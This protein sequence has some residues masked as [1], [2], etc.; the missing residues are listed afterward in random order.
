MVYESNNYNSD[1]KDLA[2]DLRQIYAKLLGEHLID[3]SEARKANN[4]YGWY[5]SL[6]DIK[7]ISKHKWRDLEKTEKAYNI[8]VEAIKELANKYPNAWLGKQ[9][10]NNQ[11]E[12]IEN[13]LRDLEEFL[14]QQ[15]EKGHVFGESG[16]TPGL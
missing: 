11:I 9:K 13:I 8:K 4:F 7:T 14:Y 12:E 5:K 10:L 3:A 6:E 15:L 16:R 2:F 1:V